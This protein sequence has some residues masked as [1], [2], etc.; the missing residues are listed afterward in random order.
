[1]RSDDR[2]RSFTVRDI[3]RTDWPL[4]ERVLGPRGGC[5]GCWCTYWNLAPKAWLAGKGETNRR[6]LKQLVARGEVQA[7]VAFAGDEP[8]GWC[9]LGPKLGFPRLAARRTL[10]VPDDEAAWAVTCFYITARWRRR[11]VATAL[12]DGAIAQARRRGVRRL[13]GYPQGAARA[14]PAS[15]SVSARPGPPRA[16]C[17][18]PPRRTSGRS[19]GRGSAPRTAP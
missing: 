18:W 9:R 13:E 11:G 8:V 6:R 7:C 5:G 3:T 16:R 15:G 14:L 12:L 2:D 17:S 19:T 4:V 1:M 10:R